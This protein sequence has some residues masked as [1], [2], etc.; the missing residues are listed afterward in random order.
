LLPEHADDYDVT[1]F[2]LDEV[3]DRPAEKAPREQS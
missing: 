3:Y 2:E 1:Q